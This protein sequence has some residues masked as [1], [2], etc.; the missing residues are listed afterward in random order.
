MSHVAEFL[1]GNLSFAYA[2]RAVRLTVASYIL[3]SF[4][5]HA[6]A[7]CFVWASWRRSSAA[8]LCFLLSCASIKRC[9]C[10]NLGRLL[11]LQVQPAKIVDW[12]IETIVDVLTPGKGT[13]ENN[14]FMR[15]LRKFEMQADKASREMDIR[16]N[17]RKWDE[18]F[19][20]WA[21]LRMV[22]LVPKTNEVWFNKLLL[23]FFNRYYSKHRMHHELIIRYLAGFLTSSIVLAVYRDIRGRCAAPTSR[24]Y[25]KAPKELA[26][27]TAQFQ[28]HALN[29]PCLSQSFPFQMTIKVLLMLEMPPVPQKLQISC[30]VYCNGCLAHLI[31]KI[32]VPFISPNSLVQK[33]FIV[34]LCI[35]LK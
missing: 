18:E 33:Y 24:K 26:S 31:R 35:A 32:F 9:E 16:V 22:F 14:W 19:P 13:G 10:F 6:G 23:I 29:N 2:F 3:P 11:L 21:H 30:G 4:M 20:W 34:L 28:R 12:I 5:W 8:P 15:S 25:W 7:L 1:L 17:L 27:A